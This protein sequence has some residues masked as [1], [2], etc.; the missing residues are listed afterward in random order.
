MKIGDSS[1]SRERKVELGDDVVEGVGGV[2]GEFHLGEA[3]L[4]LQL[5]QLL[6]FRPYAF[7][8]IVSGFA[9]RVAGQSLLARLQKLLGPPIVEILVDPFLAAELRDA[10]LAPQSRITFRTFSSAVY[11][12]RVARRRISRTTLS[13]S[14][15][16][17]LH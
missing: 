1:G 14:F 8:L 16:L 17:S 4:S 15:G 5:L 10:V 6:G 11:C 2:A 13:A 3:H 7:D 9:H 12:R